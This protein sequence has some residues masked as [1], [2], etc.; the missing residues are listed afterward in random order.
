LSC[1]IG[2][3]SFFRQLDGSIAS[4][5]RARISQ[6][7]TTVISL[8]LVTLFKASLLGSVSVCSAQYLWFV[9]RGRPI[10][11]AK[12]ESLFQ[13]R[14]NPLELANPRVILSVSFLLAAYT[15]LVPFAAIYPPGALTVASSP[16]SRG[17]GVPLSVP[18]V[19]F[20]SDFDLMSPQNVSRFSDFQIL[21]Q[22]PDYDPS[23][24]ELPERINIST[25]IGP[26]GPLEFLRQFF[27]LVVTTGEILQLPMPP[28]ENS[29]YTLSFLG[30]QLSCHRVNHFNHTEVRNTSDYKQTIFDDLIVGEDRLSKG[31]TF[32]RAGIAWPI[33]QQKVLATTNCS[34]D[35]ED[36]L[37]QYNQGSRVE[38]YVIETM[39]TNCTE[40]YVSYAANIT[41]V[42]GVRSIV[43][44]ASPLEPQPKMERYMYTTWET[45]SKDAK[46]DFDGYW[47]GNGG[48]AAFKA[49]PSYQDMKQQSKRFFRYW[50]AFFIYASFVES[51]TS[52]TRRICSPLT[53]NDCIPQYLLPNGSITNVS[54]ADCS[55]YGGGSSKSS[56]IV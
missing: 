10:A 23:H 51:I 33:I 53:G 2:H 42:K 32:E 14:H 39:T 50:N 11:L 3:Y 4:G 21:H 40:I 16:F 13:I 43:Y 19:S 46:F 41:Y 26:V 9:L 29:T 34:Q 24:K 30:P 48:P 44:K 22:Y 18:E 35:R 27:K 20:T 54:S 36:K 38:E 8:L 52:V 28:G 37:R 6:S 55:R 5:D 45:T 1:S 49:S 47:W 7:Y 12:V 15:W 31:L 56:K 17:L 25:R